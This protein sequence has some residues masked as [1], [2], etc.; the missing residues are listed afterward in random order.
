VKKYENYYILGG[1][2]TD[3]YKIMLAKRNAKIYGISDKIQFVVGDF[4]PLAAQIK[5]DVFVT[6]PPWGGPAHTKMSVIWPSS[7]FVEKVGRTIAPTML[8]HLPENVDKNEV[9][10]LFSSSI[11]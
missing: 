7:L 10:T 11:N 6:S 5:G 4:F 9:C 3:P 8:I 2:Y 1:Y